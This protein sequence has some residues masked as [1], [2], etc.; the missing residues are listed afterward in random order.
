MGKPLGQMREPACA[1]GWG[2]LLM[3]MT[4]GQGILVN[5]YLFL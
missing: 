1:A 3:I 4:E 2:Q 5:L